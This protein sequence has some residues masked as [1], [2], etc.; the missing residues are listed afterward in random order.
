MQSSEAALFAS[1][2]KIKIF[3][4]NVL[5]SSRQ[6][7]QSP[8]EYILAFE[9]IVQVHYHTCTHIIQCT[10]FPFLAR[11]V[12]LAPIMLPQLLHL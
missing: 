8:I 3:L 6:R 5:W 11:E 9:V 10:I 4:K 2:A 1:K 12:Y 7:D